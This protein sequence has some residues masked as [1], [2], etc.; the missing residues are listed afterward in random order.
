MAAAAA[1]FREQE[2]TAY[3]E[4]RDARTLIPAADETLTKKSPVAV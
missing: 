4:E 3:A 1:L 2:V